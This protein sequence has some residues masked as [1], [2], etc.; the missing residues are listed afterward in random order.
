MNTN[1]QMEEIKKK[2]DDILCFDMWSDFDASFF[3]PLISLLDI[4]SKSIIYIYEYFNNQGLDIL[5]HDK[6]INPLI[7]STQSN[8]LVN[9]L[10]VLK[11]ITLQKLIVF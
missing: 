1:N 10:S 3:W 5:L 7:E 6:V 4:N 11:K 2:C 9:Y 8:E